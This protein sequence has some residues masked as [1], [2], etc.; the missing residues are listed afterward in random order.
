MTLPLLAMFILAGV[1]PLLVDLGPEWNSSAVSLYGVLFLCSLKIGLMIRQGEIRPVA[2]TFWIF[3]YV[4]GALSALM[5]VARDDFPWPIFHTLANQHHAILLLFVVIVTFEYGYQFQA[6]RRPPKNL[7]MEFQPNQVLIIG[8]LVALWTIY[9]I[10]AL[11]GPEA[12]MGSRASVMKIFWSH[13]TTMDRL[14]RDVTLRAPIFVYMLIVAHYAFGRSIKEKIAAHVRYPFIY[15]FLLL[16]PLHFVANYPNALT[17]A[18]LGATVVA[19]ALLFMP[20]QRWSIFLFFIGFIF[21]MVFIFPQ[22][23]KNRRADGA[24]S[25]L[26]SNLEFFNNDR[27]IAYAQLINKPDFD[28]FQ[29]FCNSVQYVEE[30]GLLWGSNFVGAA[31]FWVPRNIWAD[32]PIGTGYIVG[33]YFRNP[34]DNLSSP[35]WMEGYMAFGLAGIIGLMFFY[36]RFS[37]DVDSRFLS[38]LSSERPIS[39]L[40]PVLAVFWA[41]HQMYFLRGDL[42]SSVTFSAVPLGL[43]YISASRNR[44]RPSQAPL[45]GQTPP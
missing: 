17:R 26:V 31:A 10:L 43:L 42:L 39:S 27:E 11:G 41:G 33:R 5:Q 28:V 3:M 16:L 45:P 36:G 24:E 32:K 37:A 19:P 30:N 40:Y 7:P 38:A 4:W 29:Q 44:N 8:L 9:R 15:M 20:R 23:D 2:F 13:G 12:L 35:L 21:S 1:L 14:L 18:W 22:L 34:N 25:G 6:Q